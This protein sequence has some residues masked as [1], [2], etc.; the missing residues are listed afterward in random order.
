MPQLTMSGRNSELLAV[1]GVWVVDGQPWS[2]LRFGFS[3]AGSSRSLCVAYDGT[4]QSW[5]ADSSSLLWGEMW[6]VAMN[7]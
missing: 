5:A 7:M 3:P 6:W 2:M 1:P 4:R